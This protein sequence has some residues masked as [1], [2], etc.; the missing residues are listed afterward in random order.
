MEWVVKIGG[1]LFPEYSINLARKLV[2]HDVMI[3]CGGGAL[4]NQ[5]RAYHHEID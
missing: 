2:G 3:I 1:S 4:A 5:I